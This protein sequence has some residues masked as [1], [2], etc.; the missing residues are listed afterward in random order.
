L[1][2]LKVL[3]LGDT[4]ITDSG[5]QQLAKLEMLVD[6]DLTGTQIT[7][8]GEDKLQAARPNLAIKPPKP[9]IEKSS[10]VSPLIGTTSENWST[11]DLSNLNIHLYCLV[12]DGVYLNCDGAAIFHE[13][14]ALTLRQSSDLLA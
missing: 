9:V 8:A 5:L 14:A 7:K 3:A 12:L 6:L 10:A 1:Q 2:S 4:P 13:A 11:T